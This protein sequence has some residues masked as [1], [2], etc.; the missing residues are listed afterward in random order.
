MATPIPDAI[1]NDI[2]KTNFPNLLQLNLTN[3]DLTNIEFL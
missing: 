3:N 2:F 1:L